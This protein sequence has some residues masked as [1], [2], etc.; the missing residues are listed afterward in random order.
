[1]RE[2]FLLWSAALIAFG[3]CVFAAFVF[4]DFALFSRSPVELPVHWFE[5][6]RQ[7]R[8]LTELTFWMNGALSGRSPIAWHS[9]GLALHLI[10]VTLVWDVLRKLIGARAALIAAAIFA[11]HPM[12]TQP[13]AYVFARGTLLAALFS[14]LAMRSWIAGRFWIA[15]IWFTVA[16]LAKEECA[17]L[18]LVL[19]LLPVPGNWR[20]FSAMLAV[21]LAIG[22]RTM[23]A[24][25]TLQGSGAGAQ[26]GISPAAYLASQ[27]VAIWRYLRLLI[28][29]WGFSIDPALRQP[30]LFIAILAGVALAAICLVPFRGR[31][32]FLMGL[33]LLAPSSSILP[34]ADLAADR[35]MYLPMVAFCAC[36]GILLEAVDRRATIAIVLGLMALSIHESILWMNPEAL[37]R[38]AERQ[39]PWAVRPRIQLARLLPAA[40]GLAQLDIESKDPMVATER[41]RLLLTLGRPA[42]ALSAFGLALA[43]DPNDAKAISN[44]AVALAAL[45]SRDAAIAEFQRALEHD[46]CLTDA[47]ENLARLGV[48]AIA[49]VDCR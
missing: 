43:E 5:C 1:L 12:M 39:A 17:A 37:W 21:A 22:V 15:A 7:T 13:V 9:V 41:G 4:D 45:G 3:G 34:A 46:R 33:V 18:P 27:G 29:P 30:S 14:L 42:E 48:T 6:F 16:M 20:A 28:V 32:W 35:R 38:D 31:F 47:R 36:I 44:R 19:I 10:C 2:K 25:A 40:E 26:S 23:L 49:P 8:P 24:A 11:V